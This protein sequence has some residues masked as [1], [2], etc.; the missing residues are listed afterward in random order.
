MVNKP[1]F[2]FKQS[3]K[4]VK[5]HDGDEI[6][7]H[8]AKSLWT[9]FRTKMLLRKTKKKRETL[10]LSRCVV[11]FF[12]KGFVWVCLPTNRGLS[13][14]DPP[15]KIQLLIIIFPYIFPKPCW[16]TQKMFGHLGMIHDDSPMPI[17]IPV[18]E[19]IK[20]DQSHPDHQI[21]PL[22]N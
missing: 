22:V 11:L 8:V 9:L 4:L 20:Y 18:L 14:N 17:I 10:A 16:G 5:C 7:Q 12:T 1:T 21:Y 13:E 6:C 19:N 2:I 15:K 3:M